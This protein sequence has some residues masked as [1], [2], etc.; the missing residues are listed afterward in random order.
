MAHSVEARLPFLD[1][2]LVTLMFKLSS[3]WKMNGPWNKYILR[4]AMTGVI[5]ESVRRRID[6]MGF[7]VP[8]RQWLTTALFEPFNDLLESRDIKESGL[9]NI[10][11]IRSSLESQ[12]EPGKKD[13]STALFNIAQ[14]Q[15]WSRNHSSMLS[16]HI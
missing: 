6:K 5:P 12:R 2:R 9:Y 16:T 14:F 13:V 11:A 7:P 10:E 8:C 1:Y 3:R 15:L 4:Q